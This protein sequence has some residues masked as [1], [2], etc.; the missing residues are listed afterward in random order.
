MNPF[1]NY[2]CFNYDSQCLRSKIKFVWGCGA[3]RQYERIFILKIKP[4]SII[5]MVN[6]SPFRHCHWFYYLSQC[7]RRR[8][9]FVWGS[10]ASRQSESISIFKKK[11]FPLL[12]QR[13]NWSPF[14]HYHCFYYHSQCLRIKIK[15]VW[16]CGA[17]RQSESISISKNKA[18]PL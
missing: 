15:F 1:R 13:V 10:G 11:A 2:H 16:R 12:F 7:L 9:K 14:E 4:F 18:P 3:S 17:S 5:Q 8:I 6:C